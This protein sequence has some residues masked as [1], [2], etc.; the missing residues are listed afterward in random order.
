MMSDLRMRGRVLRIVAVSLC[1]ILHR[2]SDSS[3]HISPPKS[4]DPGHARPQCRRHDLDPVVPWQPSDEAGPTSLQGGRDPPCPPAPMLSGTV[5]PHYTEIE[6]G[7][8]HHDEA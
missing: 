6:N 1:P 8:L 4:R 7:G 2:L 5:H 3:A